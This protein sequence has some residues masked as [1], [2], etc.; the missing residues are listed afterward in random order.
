MAAAQTRKRPS[1]ASSL[2]RECIQN[3]HM[4]FRL[5]GGALQTLRDEANASGRSVAGLF[6]KRAGVMLLDGSPRFSINAEKCVRHFG[7]SLSE[8]MLRRLHR[9][10]A[11]RGVPVAA[12][13]ELVASYVWQGEMR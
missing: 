13:G 2:R 4:H 12:L 9:F 10:A 5:S 3:T 8:H 11:A 1:G 7:V 6:R